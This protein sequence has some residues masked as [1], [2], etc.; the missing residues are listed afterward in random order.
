MRFQSFLLLAAALFERF[1]RLLDLFRC[2]FVLLVELHH[3]WRGDRLHTIEDARVE[4]AHITLVKHHRDRHDEREVLG[5]PEVVVLEREH[6]V[7]PV[8]QHHHHRRLGCRRR[9][10][11]LEDRLRRATSEQQKCERREHR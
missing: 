9:R 1:S 2:R 7:R 4:R 11:E 10:N 3:V 8:A 6:R 5:G